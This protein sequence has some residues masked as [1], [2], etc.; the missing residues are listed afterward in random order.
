VRCQVM[1]AVKYVIVVDKGDVVE[2]DGRGY[3][4]NLAVMVLIHYVRLL[5]VERKLVIIVGKS[6]QVIESEISTMME[7]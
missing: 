4:R 1:G 6:S 7:S 3:T 5:N 2:V